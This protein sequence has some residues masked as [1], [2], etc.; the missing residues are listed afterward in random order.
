ML[1]ALLIYLLYKIVLE[2]RHK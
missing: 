1:Q 2:V